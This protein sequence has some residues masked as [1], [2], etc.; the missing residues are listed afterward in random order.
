[1][2]AP[3]PRGCRVVRRAKTAVDILRSSSIGRPHAVITRLFHAGLNTHNQRNY[4]HNYCHW[5]QGKCVRINK[6]QVHGSVMI[7]QN[8]RQLP[9]CIFS[10]K[11]A[12]FLS[13]KRVTERISNF[14][15]AS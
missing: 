11:I 12:T 6:S 14:K 4:H 15:G 3:P 13:L 5:L 10:V 2:R 8:C 1:M 9:V 7:L